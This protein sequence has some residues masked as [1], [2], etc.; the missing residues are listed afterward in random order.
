MGGGG[1]YNRSLSRMCI[2]KS[3][4]WGGGGGGGENIKRCMSSFFF[5]VV[6]GGGGGG[7]G[8]FVIHRGVRLN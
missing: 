3:V 6:W 4:P 7:G 5:N 1:R 2:Y 8:M